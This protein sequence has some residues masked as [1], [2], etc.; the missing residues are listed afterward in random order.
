VGRNSIT[1]I[2]WKFN[3]LF[4][5]LIVLLLF[6]PTFL[7]GKIENNRAIEFPDIPGYLTLVCDLHMHTVFSDGR[8]YP[9]IRV[10]EAE[11]DN[12]D[13]IAT[14]EHLEYQ[15]W[16]QDIPHPD[17][18]RSFQIA[19]KSAEKT[20]V[21]VINGSEI[22]RSMP[23]GHANAIFV[24]DANKLLIDDPIEVF[25]EARLQDAFIFW[26]HPHWIKQSPDASVPLDKMHITLIKEGLLE[27]IEVVNDTTYSDEALQLALDYDLTI[28]GT[29][30]IHGIVDWKYKIPFGGHRPVT[31]VFASEKTP[32]SLKKALRARRTVVWYKNNLIGKHKN[33][34]NLINAC[35]D[36]KDATYLKKSFVVN[37][38]LINNSDASFSLRNISRYNFHTDVDL[39]TIN[40]HGEKI[41]NIKTKEK[42]RKFALQ[43]EVLNAL[44]AP[45]TH[46]VINIQIKPKF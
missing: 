30:D 5:I 22:T 33:V 37:V 20:E 13:V 27:G 38:K 43:F 39:I 36:T 41:L 18:N 29:S 1:D 40:P 3:L 26:N 34:V 14:T 9:S 11:K 10:K 17:R 24:K 12:V 45:A 2:T 16:K 15:P 35:L 23:P 25:K 7:D 32:S 6:S 28:L 44:S 19:T 21:M 46:P 31:L 8:V 42:I 4:T